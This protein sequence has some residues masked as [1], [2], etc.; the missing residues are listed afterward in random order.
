MLQRIQT[1]ADQIQ[2]KIIDSN[3]EK[4]KIDKI[5]EMGKVSDDF[6][7]NKVAV[8]TILDSGSQVDFIEY[9]ESLAA[10]TNNKIELKI[11]KDSS[12]SDDKLAKPAPKPVAKTADDNNDASV[13]DPKKSIEDGLVYKQ[14]I[15]MQANIEGD[16]GSLLN[17]VHKLENNKYYVNVISLNLQKAFVQK[18]S[19][20][21]DGSVSSSIFLPATNQSNAGSASSADSQGDPVLKSSLTIIVYTE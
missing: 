13:K 14:Y 21:G 9:V 1:K 11:L 6:E 18:E 16:Y 8:G 20:T 7:K 4:A 12:K 10:E 2:E 15:S 5:P 19:A 17:F 3:L